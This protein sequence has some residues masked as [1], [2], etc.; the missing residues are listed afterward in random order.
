[1]SLKK[2]IKAINKYQKFLITSHVNLD[3]DAICSELALAEFLKSRGKEVHIVN[4]CEVPTAYK[5]LPKIKNL[6]IY[7][8]KDI[9]N[10]DVA[11]L[12]DCFDINRTGKVAR[13]ISEDKFLI[14]ID[15]HISNAIFANINWI[16]PNASS[17]AEI[18]YKMFEI[19]NYKINK[20]IATFLY[21][22]I[23]T[24]TG[25][26]RYNN[27]SSYTHKIAADLLRWKLPVNRIYQRI[28]ESNPVS[29]IRLFINLVR[30]FKLD[31]TGRIAWLKMKRNSFPK[32][33][34]SMDLSEHI[35]GFLRSIKGVEVIALFRELENKNQVR[36]NLRSN[37]KIDV[38]K[39]ATSFDG[40]GHK[41][42][43]GC[44][45]KGSLGQVEQLIIPRL[46]KL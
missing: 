40:G 30:S 13:L 28:Y 46:K 10:F 45:I 12:L 4:D 2:I 33:K 19:A 39:I 23:L 6:N 37:S 21:V 35:L 32:N 36:V 38:R 42:A 1:M 24:D 27:T 5:F 44:T 15:H 16:E 29:D 43:S 11:I 8:K 9:Y 14:A 41:A 25:S 18:L 26:F 3:G 20:E 7:R 17:T 22:G 31:S 34:V